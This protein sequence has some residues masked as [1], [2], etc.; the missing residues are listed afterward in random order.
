VE[1]FGLI[2]MINVTNVTNVI[3]IG[4]LDLIDYDCNVTFDDVKIIEH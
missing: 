4:H 1:F 3:Q 2:N